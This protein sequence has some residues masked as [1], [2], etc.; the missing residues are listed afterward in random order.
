M[1]RISN[2]FLK[3]LPENWIYYLVFLF[4][5]ILDS[6]SILSNWN[7]AQ[8]FMLYI[9]EERNDP[10]NYRDIALINSITKIFTYILNSR[11]SHFCE[12][13]KLY[14]RISDGENI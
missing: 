7:K 5:K 12:N 9:K 10:N 3:V 2:N 14:I 1:D 4:N 6:E 11:I 8:N 13:N